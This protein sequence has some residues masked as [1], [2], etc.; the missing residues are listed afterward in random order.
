MRERRQTIS[1][2]RISLNV[3]FY[4]TFLKKFILYVF[5]VLLVVRLLESEHCFEIQIHA[6]HASVINI[7]EVKQKEGA[8]NGCAYQNICATCRTHLSY[9]FISNYN[10]L[11]RLV[12][13]R[14]NNS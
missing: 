13:G 14:V 2:V 7:Q 3:V 1:H 4:F 11:M 9:F 10:V 5:R 6:L 12:Q 8:E